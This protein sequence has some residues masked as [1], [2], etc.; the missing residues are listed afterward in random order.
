MR[1][2]ESGGGGIGDTEDTAAAN[3]EDSNSRA[4]DHNADKHSALGGFAVSESANRA[5]YT[6]MQST[7]SDTAKRFSHCLEGLRGASLDEAKA[8][9]EAYLKAGEDLA[10]GLE[11]DIEESGTQHRVQSGRGNGPPQCS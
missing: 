11:E 8:K 4:V 5:Q 6:Q 3:A 1:E 7:L 2:R 10:A 9:V